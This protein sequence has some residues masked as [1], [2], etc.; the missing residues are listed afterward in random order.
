MNQTTLRT[1]AGLA[2]AAGV[3]GGALAQERPDFRPFDEVSRGYTKVETAP[4]EGSLF[5]LYINNKEEQLLAEMPRGWERKKFFLAATPAGGVIFSGLQGPDRYVYWKRY[6]KRIALVEPNLGTRS[7]AE[8]ASKDSVD[9]IFP[10]RVLLDVPI[11]AIGPNKQPVI[12][13]DN[14]LVDNSGR[15]AGMAL[16]GRL[17]TIEKAKAFPQN[18]E[19]SIKA[20][21][22]AGEFMILHYSISEVPE[23]SSY[24]PRESDERIG[25][26]TTDYRDL[27]LYGTDTN[28]KSYINRW[29]LEKRDPKLKMSPPKEPIT[30]Y[31][32]HT[33]PVRY[34]RYVQEGVLQWNAAFEKIGYL[35]AIKVE[36]QDELTGLHMEKDPE[37][38]RYNFVRWL[39]NDIATA[40]GPSRA[41]PLTGQIL[42]ADIVLTDG[43]IRAFFGDYEGRP[44]AEIESLTPETLTWLE[45]FPQW[46]PRIQLLP[47]AERE[48]VMADRRR[49]AAMGDADPA[50]SL[51]DPVIAASPEL[52]E[53]ADWIGCDHELCLVGAMKAR[54]MAFAGLQF[55]VGGLIEN[56]VANGEE[57][58]DGIPEKF[59]GQQLA[60]LTA[61][62][63]GHTL[64]LRH[65]FKSS[66][67]YTMEEVNSEE[68]LG[69]RANSG[70]VMD[71]LPTNWNVE[72]GEIQGDFAMIGIGPYDM[73]AIEYGYTDGNLEEVLARVGEPEHVYLTDEDASGPDPL[74]R[75][76]DFSADPH[77]YAQS[78]ITLIGQQRERL[79]TEYVK[80]GDSWERA[81]RGYT[82]TL[83]MQRR[84]IDMMA[85]W[86]GGTHVNRV[87]KGDPDTGDPL[88]PA[89][90]EKQR[91]ALAFLIDNA[92]RDE[93]YGLS[94][95]LLNKMT[96]ERWAGGVRGE[97]TWPV[98]EQVAAVQGLAV[99][100]VLNPTTLSRVYNNELRI[101]PGEDALTLPELIG[102]MF[103]ACYTEL[104][105]AKP[106]GNFTEREP[107]IS[108]L[109]RN[110]Q[111]DMTDRLIA[112]ATNKARLD[113]PVRQ[114]CLFFL[115]KL[116]ER[117]AAMM[118]NTGGIDSYTL[119]H[120]MD[121]H[122]RTSRALDAIYIAD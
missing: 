79:L 115:K 32:E 98:V 112:V 101:D 107:M 121:M 76:Y 9:R 68:F 18:I 29:H 111:A 20:P 118:K 104:M 74:A 77:A 103:D 84:M 36:Q 56:A 27:G 33:V 70:S 109:R 26:F 105:S 16:N 73:W 93:A 60:H 89:A 100:L 97:P 39:N 71:Y 23:R 34:R 37:D 102:T 95:E 114:Q 43:W 61:H 66:S 51:R 35:N 94:P 46:D 42:D 12:D 1:I 8:Q 92:F 11:V 54:D 119:A 10:D 117:L 110:L 63:V 30:F 62:E 58:I 85:N 22:P 4:G 96:I 80:D 48:Q 13:L 86:I 122:E 67:I 64:G 53:L 14:L 6:D 90:V 116:D 88:V 7:S 81:R 106:R 59:I 55:Q 82:R 75:R 78:M 21:S 2:L 83:S 44:S 87:K 45:E 52:A 31:I 50:M 72:N 113:R 120:L 47:P 3:T 65:N 5:G 19:I 49:R 41:H 99:T 24:K 91:E 28:W 108:A 69:K 40:I 38:V 57:L 25:Y 17:A 15:L